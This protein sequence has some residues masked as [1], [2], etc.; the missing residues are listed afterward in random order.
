MLRIYDSDKNEINL[1]D[2]TLFNGGFTKIQIILI[3]SILF[4]DGN[5]QSN[6]N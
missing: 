3:I 1:N 4:N 5:N 6:N 2:K